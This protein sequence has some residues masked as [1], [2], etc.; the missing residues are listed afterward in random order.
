MPASM[1]LVRQVRTP[2]FNVRLERT[3]ARTL[4]VPLLRSD[5]RA[6]CLCRPATKMCAR[7]LNLLRS[8]Q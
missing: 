5:A 8:S 2:S 3:C 1:P 4:S 6:D 7:A